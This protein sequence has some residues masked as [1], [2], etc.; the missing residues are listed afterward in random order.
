M[1]RFLLHRLSQSIILLL[2][3]TLITFFLINLAPGGPAAT[4]RMEASPEER[5]AMEERLGLD[6]PVYI[7]YLTWIKDAARGDLGVSFTSSEPVIQRIADRLPYTIE[8][9]F[10]TIFFSVTIGIVLGVISAIKRGRAQDHVINFFSVIGLSLPAFWL[11][12]MLILFFSIK[13]GWLPSSGVGPRGSEFDLWGWIAHLIM[14]VLILTTTVLP[15]IVRFTR[16]SMLE[17]ISQNYIR[18]ARAKGA[19]ES[20]VLYVHA[21]R[22]ALIPVVTIIGVLIPRLLS[23]AVITE[24]IFGWTGIGT[25]VIEAAKG[26][27]YPLVMGV[28]VVITIIVVISNLLVDLVYSRID[29]RVKNVS[30]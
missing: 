19:K 20:V 25:L 6:Q 4:M 13:L 10:F 29:P 12:L 8:L 5:E 18:T 9:T 11:G 2:I 16:S 23:G 17:V 30:A 24:A 1:P 15:N 28:T 22:N 7:R 14:P 27:D 21:L 3:V 26:R